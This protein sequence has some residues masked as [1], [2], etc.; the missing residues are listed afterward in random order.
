MLGHW[1][2][3]RSV[4]RDKKP[5]KVAR[6]VSLLPN[7]VRRGFLVQSTQ[8]PIIQAV[9]WLSRHRGFKKPA[10]T[11][12]QT[13]SRTTKTTSSRGNAIF[14]ILRTA[15]CQIA[16]LPLSAGC[17]VL[18]YGRYGQFV[19]SV[20]GAVDFPFFVRSAHSPQ[21][22]LWRKV[23]CT[24]TRTIDVVSAAF[25]QNAHPHFECLERSVLADAC[26]NCFKLIPSLLQ[27][28]S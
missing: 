8:L 1:E 3:R 16:F 22:D 24:A 18:R 23:F 4:A 21:S 12:T 10:V 25:A 27:H 9:G 2:H 13:T 5:C 28:G 11:P 17:E 26:G 14:P 15:H 19:V 20:D 6:Q 7:E